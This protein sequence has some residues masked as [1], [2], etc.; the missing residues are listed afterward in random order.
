MAC[1]TV[2]ALMKRLAIFLLLCIL[3]AAAVVG[4][5]AW[6]WRERKLKDDVR[7]REEASAENTAAGRLG[8]KTQALLPHP[9]D[10]RAALEDVLRLPPDRRFLLAARELAGL[11]VAARFADGRWILTLGKREFGRVPELPDFTDWMKVLAPLAKDW[12]ATAKVTG[13]APRIRALRGHKEAF[14][15]VR[16]AQTKWSR[17]DHGAAVLHDAASAAASLVLLAP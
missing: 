7:L 11:E 15:A 12:V 13:K 6:R 2:R 8:L 9:L 17:G 4:E 5:Q 10:R 3:G 14:A 16:E 1:V